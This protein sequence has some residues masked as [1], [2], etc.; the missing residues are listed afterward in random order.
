MTKK[1]IINPVTRISGFMEIQADIENNQ[2][3]DAKTEGLLFRGFEKM[4][5]GR[6]PFDAVYFTQR[7]CGICSTAHSMASTLALED[8]MGVVPTE[9]GRY[10][11]DILHGCEFLQNHIRHF[12]Q[13]TIPDFVKLPEDYPLFKLEHSD[14]RLPKEKNDRLVKDYFDSLDL[15]RSAHEMLAVLGGK[16][17]HNHGV[18]IGGISTQ[19]TTDKIIKIK[20]ILHSIREFIHD[21]MLPDVYTIS[22]YYKDYF[23]IGRGYGNLLSF[24]CFDNYKTLGTLYVNPLVYTDGRISTFNPDYITEKIDYA[25]Y[26]DRQSSGKPFE[27]DLGRMASSEAQCNDQ[28]EADMNKP[29][30]YSWVKAPRYNNLP[31]ETGP[32]ARQ[33]LSGEYRNGISTM[34]RTIARVLEAR[35]ITLIISTLLENLIPGISVQKEYSIPETAEGKGLIDTTRGTLGHWLKINNQVISFYQIITPSAWNLSTR[36]SNGLKGTAEQ[37]LIGTAVRDINNPVEL[38]RTIRSFD[39]CVSC[40]THIYTGGK[41]INTIQVIP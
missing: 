12:Y 20:S 15:S 8:A 35:K 34:D 19:A 21:R 26:K 39:P 36:S 33:W 6:S 7:I 38:G 27:S 14:F 23:A 10:L 41:H 30:A 4:L 13:Y 17:P 22:E 1:I 31:F 18:F 3:V 2:I 28:P 25:W 5:Q 37:A 11:R 40:A 9:Q 16:V 29:Q 24:G 32:L